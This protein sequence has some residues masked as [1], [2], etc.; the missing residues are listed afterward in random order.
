MSKYN[1]LSYKQA[2]KWE[3]LAKKLGV[4]K[5]ARGKGGFMRVYQSVGGDANKLKTIMFKNESWWNRRNNFVKRHMAQVKRNK[6]SLFTS[7][8]TPTRRHLAL[9]MWAYSPSL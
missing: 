2:A 4:S 7:D 5:V 9:I 1:W 3:P 8:G 6:E